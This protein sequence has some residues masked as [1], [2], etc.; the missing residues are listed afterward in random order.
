[1]QSL[2]GGKCVLLNLLSP[3]NR[4][5]RSM[6]EEYGILQEIEKFKGIQYI[7]T[8]SL[9]GAPNQRMLIDPQAKPRQS[10]RKF[11]FV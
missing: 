4:F 11:K 9:G 5:Y 10:Q 3:P 7:L 1:M 6:V 2:K 8:E